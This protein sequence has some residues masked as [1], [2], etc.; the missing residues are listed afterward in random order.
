MLDRL[1]YLMRTP[2]P[3]NCDEMIHWSNA[4]GSRLFQVL[5]VVSFCSVRGGAAWSQEEWR[6]VEDLRIGAGRG[7]TFNAVASLDVAADGRIVVL[8]SANYT[9]QIFSPDGR[10]QAQF[11]RRGA[12]V[13]EFAHGAQAVTVA[14]PLVYVSDP[15]NERVHR[16][17]LSGNLR[18][19]FRLARS[20]GLPLSWAGLPNGE[21]LGLIASPAARGSARETSLVRLDLS[22]TARDTIF[23]YR[24]APPFEVNSLNIPLAGPAVIW[25]RA[26]DGTIYSAISDRYEIT[27]HRQGRPSRQIR[28]TQERVTVPDSI[29]RA[30]TAFY[31]RAAQSLGY[32]AAMREQLLRTVRIP[33]VAPVLNSIAAGR[34][35]VLFVERVTGIRVRANGS[36]VEVVGKWEAIDTAGKVV[37]RLSAPEGLRLVRARADH[38]YALL[39]GARGEPFV[40]RYR[41]VRPAGAQFTNDDAR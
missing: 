27:V 38:I 23:R 41:I 1:R 14:G 22:G 18:R 32:D 19:S 35:G 24:T 15:N 37:A 25:S 31:Q 30:I 34:D 13:G 26:D 8:D 4:M 17:D 21:L 2:A 16:Y 20:S 12:T 9:V 36:G 33:A 6:L 39:H 28:G 7:A 40:V 3:S 10:P 5:L 29:R 11:G